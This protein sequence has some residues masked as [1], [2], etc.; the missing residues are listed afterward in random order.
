[1]ESPNG[2]MV[3]PAEYVD[4]EE[5]DEKDDVAIIHPDQLG[6]DSSVPEKPRADSCM[7][8]N[9]LPPSSSAKIYFSRGYERDYIPTY[10]RKPTHYRGR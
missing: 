8:I 4:Q 9:I 2:M 1:M 5:L 3:D 6:S 10:D 7:L